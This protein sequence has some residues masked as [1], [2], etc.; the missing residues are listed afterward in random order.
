VHGPTRILFIHHSVGRYLLRDGAIRDRLRSLDPALVLW[1]HDYNKVGLTGPDGAPASGAFPV[2]GDNTDP[3]GF[4]RLFAGADNE[5]RHARARALEFD[6]VAL[7]SCYPNS[8][9][10]SDEELQEIKDTY[11]SLVRSLT[12]L[13]GVEFVLLTSPPLAPLRTSAAQARRARS[14]ATWLAETTA[15]TAALNVTVLDLFDLLADRDDHRL[16]KEYRRLLPVDSHPNRRAGQEVGDALAATLA[17]AASR[18]RT[19][20]S[21]A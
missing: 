12:E 7:K 2:P 16:R 11:R 3:D 4:L 9:I 5:A 19:R 8:A 18:A 1:D 20:A 15:E 21:A 17:A 13:H 14:L 6:V 10:G